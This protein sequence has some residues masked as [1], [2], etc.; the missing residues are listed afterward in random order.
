MMLDF[1]RGGPDWAPGEE[2]DS[3]SDRDDHEV[4][5]SWADLAIWAAI[6]LLVVAGGI[7]LAVMAYDAGLA[8]QARLQ[9]WS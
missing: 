8:L 6:L 2:W 7:V 9:W 4:D 3:D 5:A 1:G